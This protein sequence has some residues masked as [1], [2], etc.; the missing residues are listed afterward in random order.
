MIPQKLEPALR[1]HRERLRELHAR[2]RQ[3]N[4]PG[5]E[6]PEALERK[7]SKAGEKFIWFWPSRSL[8]RDQRTG[9]TC[10]T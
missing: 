7:W 1:A 4:L 3:A 2:D 8:M 6:L 9:I 10:W 5:V